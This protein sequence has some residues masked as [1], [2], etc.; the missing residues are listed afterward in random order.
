MRSE[1]EEV[2]L[3]TEVPLISKNIKKLLMKNNYEEINVTLC[4]TG[5][6]NPSC[7]HSYCSQE[8]S[9]SKILFQKCARN[10]KN[11]AEGKQLPSDLLEG[12][13]CGIG[14]EAEDWRG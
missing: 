3:Q 4:L 2:S 14:K 9:V 7:S 6:A 12:R 1:P 11:K 8:D 13:A 10:S 5:Q